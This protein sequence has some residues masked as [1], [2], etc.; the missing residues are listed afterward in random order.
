VRGDKNLYGRWAW[1]RD[2]ATA[3]NGRVENWF[4]LMDSWYDTTNDETG[5]LNGYRW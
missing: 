2:G 4:E 3:G 5:G 1:C